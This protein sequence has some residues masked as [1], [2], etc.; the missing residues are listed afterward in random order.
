MS[1]NYHTS[2]Y[3]DGQ[4]CVS[5]SDMQAWEQGVI[6]AQPARGHELMEIAG[7]E[8]AQHVLE[9][10]KNIKEVLIFCGYGN[11]LV[12]RTDVGVRGGANYFEEAG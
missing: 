5:P 2:K 3:Q 6:K 12:F 1:F 10:Y 4:Y 7:R 9:H 11:N 8:V